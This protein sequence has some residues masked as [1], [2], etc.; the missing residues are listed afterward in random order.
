MNESQIAFISGHRVITEEE[1]N[2]HYVPLLDAALERG[3]KFLV[4][5]YYGVDHMAQKYLLSKGCP[6]EMLVVHHMLENPR[7]CESNFTIGGYESDEQRDNSMTFLSDYDIAWV[8]PGKENSGTAQNLARRERYHILGQIESSQ[9][10][11][12]MA[13]G[14]QV[15]PKFIKFFEAMEEHLRKEWSKISK[16]YVHSDDKTS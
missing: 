14:K 1:F 6:H 4:G 15:S 11:L 13:L 2:E 9:S 5:D 7:C 10:N 8:R 12:Y 16:E 3:D